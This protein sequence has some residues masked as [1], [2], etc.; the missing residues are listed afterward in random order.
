MAVSGNPFLSGEF[1]KFDFAA[2]MDP[3]KFAEQFEKFDLSSM[4]WKFST[5]APLRGEL[6]KQLVDRFPGQLV[7]FYG[8]T[9]GG[10]STLFFVNNH[11]NKLD[12]VG[13]AAPG[14]EGSSTGCGNDCEPVP[15]SAPTG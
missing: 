7:E 2:F 12:S 14:F 10:T 13:P 9:E 15:S 5:S 4:Q 3:S 8:L 6:K 1:P 11:P